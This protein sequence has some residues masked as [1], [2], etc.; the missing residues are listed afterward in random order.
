LDYLGS[1]SPYTINKST[2]IILRVES[3]K[4]HFATKPDL[5]KAV[6]GISF[7]LCLGETIGIVGESGS[8]KSVSML[9]ILQ[10]IES[11][12]KVVDGAVTYF[13]E[14]ASIDLLSLSEYEISKYR[15]AKIGMI[16]QQAISSFNPVQKIGKQL[17]EAVLIHNKSSVGLDLLLKDLLQKVEL[18]D[19]ERILAAYPHQL[20]GGQL[21]RFMIAMAIINKP[22]ILI[23]DEPTTGLDVITQKSV[24]KLLLNLKEELGM[25]MIFISHDLGVISEMADRTI[26]M[27]QGV[28]V[29]KGKTEDLFTKPQ[30]PY[31][32][33]LLLCRPSIKYKSRRLPTYEVLSNGV[34]VN[35]KIFAPFTSDEIRSHQSLMQSAPIILNACGLNKSFNDQNGVFK[36]PKNQVH[37]VIDLSFELRKGEVLG[38]V[39]ES[40]SG[41]STLA[42]LLLNLELPDSGAVYYEGVSIQ[43]LSKKEFK[44]F[45]KALQIIFQ[46]VNGSLDP[47][48]SVGAVIEFALKIHFPQASKKERK[49]RVIN[50]LDQVGLSDKYLSRLP[51]ELSGGEKQRVCIARAIS[52]EPKVLICDECVSALDVSVQAQILNLLLD[53]RDILGLSLIFISHDISVI[54]FMSDRILVMQEGRVVERGYT[55]AVLSHPKVEYTR[56]LLD[57]IPSGS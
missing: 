45:R 41:K 11:P 46:D 31:A 20:S 57:S 5:I 33:A 21:Q 18:Q 12:G 19:Y 22:K 53:L 27:K 50:L 36:K 17:K 8:G 32:Q 40:G 38:V 9:S 3:L 4:T 55:T 35:S 44:P 7:D 14:N 48:M 39:G 16:Y 25:S 42:M 24:L 6:D 54:N 30:S 26:V 1:K 29:E 51:H 47:K 37:A 34:D 52:V 43:A 23:A 56:M 28:I 13:D 10:L 2:N 15:G 49:Q